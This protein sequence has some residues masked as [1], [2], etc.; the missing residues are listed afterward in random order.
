[1]THS[2]N[3]IT[4]WIAI[5]NK[6]LTFNRTTVQG[7]QIADKKI[8]ILMELAILVILMMMVMVSKI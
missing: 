5:T 3:Y 2:G 6:T 4:L 1:M 8:L 7:Y